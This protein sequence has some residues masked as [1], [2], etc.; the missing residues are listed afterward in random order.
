MS[1]SKTIVSATIA[2]VLVQNLGCSG[3]TS[4]GGGD[5]GGGGTAA[6]ELGGGT[7]GSGG[8]Q[9]NGGAV[10]TGG[11]LATGGST[12]SGGAQSTGGSLTSGGT[13]TAVQCGTAVCSPSQECCNAS[14]S[15]CVP[16]GYGC[17]AME[18]GSGGSSSI[19]GASATGGSSGLPGL[20]QACV[21]KTCAT[22]LTPVE[23]YG[24]AGTAGPLFCGCEIPCPDDECPS[25]MQCNYVFDGPGAVCY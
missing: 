24:I 7:P 13:G 14:C 10:N 23:F 8:A 3:G 16:K 6:V 19:G 12:S 9:G 5:S 18:C 1:S 4:L 17:I 21:D 11:M 20:H 2:A 25:G 15:L 22:G